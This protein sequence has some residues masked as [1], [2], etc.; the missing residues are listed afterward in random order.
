MAELRKPARQSAPGTAA[1]SGGQ[2][3]AAADSGVRDTVGTK[4]ARPQAAPVQA[5][6]VSLVGAGPG[7]PGLITVK[8]RE[9]LRSADCV[10]YDLLANPQLLEEAP[11][12]CEKIYAGKRPAAI[13]CPRRKLRS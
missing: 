10:I 6:F 4:S 1:D 5:G 9:A 8:G 7:D 3:N 12:G 11:A 13:P 2:K